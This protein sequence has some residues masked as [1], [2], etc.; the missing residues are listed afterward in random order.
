MTI[1]TTRRNAAIAAFAAAILTA[2]A[3]SSTPP[4]VTSHGTVTLYSGLLSGTNVQDGY[5]DITAGSQVTVTDSTGKV[6]GTGTLAA[7]SSMT[8]AMVDYASLAAKLPSY[9]LTQD[10]AVYDFTV[11]GLPGGLP[12][13]G[14][15]VG[16]NRGTV[17]QTAAQVK[18]PALT[19]GSLSG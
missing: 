12:R 11:A 18:A 7:D 15:Q 3:C 8:T 2:A 1:T 17:W 10:V 4:P 13:Y 14:F 19:L 6:I 9:D 16:Q 5:P